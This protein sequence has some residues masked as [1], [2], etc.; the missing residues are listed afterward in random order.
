MSDLAPGRHERIGKRER[1][2]GWC[3]THEKPSATSN[4]YCHNLWWLWRVDECEI[5]WRERL[6][7]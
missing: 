2:L 5:R 1:A 7:R 4:T 3:L 6:E